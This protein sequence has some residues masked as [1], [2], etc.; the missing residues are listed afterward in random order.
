MN[1]AAGRWRWLLA[2]LV[3]L[4]LWS[5]L[6]VRTYAWTVLLRDSGVVNQ[7]LQRVHLIGQPLPL[8][9]NTLGV[10]IAANARTTELTIA[11]PRGDDAAAATKPE[12]D[13][14][15]DL[16]CLRIVAHI[17]IIMQVLRDEQLV[18]EDQE[19]E[20]NVLVSY[21]QALHKEGKRDMTPVY[22]SRLQKS[23]YVATM[24][25]VL[26]DITDSSER[27]NVVT[28][29]LQ[30]GMDVT[31]VIQALLEKTLDNITSATPAKPFTILEDTIDQRC[32][33]RRVNTSFFPD[34]VTKE[35]EDLVKALEWFLLL[36]GHWD[37]TF[38]AL[39]TAL[40]AVLGMLVALAMDDTDNHSLWQLRLRT[41]HLR[42]FQ[43]PKGGRSKDLSD[44][45]PYRPPLQR[46]RLKTSR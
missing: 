41:T 18:V 45:W 29:M 25:M 20:D 3:V 6:L 5:S 16:V 1:Q 24:A 34:A 43:E 32:P 14:A 28:L 22:A 19:M 38:D 30:H 40:R 36:P 8:M 37:E 46:R 10:A 7:L 35:Q 9:G 13:A 11:H 15:L 12:A 21:I 2:A 39:T 17:S 26:P 4:P 42:E 31:A 33:G 44:P 23:R 27:Q